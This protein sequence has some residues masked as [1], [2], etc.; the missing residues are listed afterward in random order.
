MAGVNPSLAQSLARQLL[1]IKAMGITMLVIEHNMSVIAEICDQ[2]T[3]LAAGK[4][5]ARGSF[6]EI[7]GNPPIWGA[8]HEPARGLR[9]GRRL[10]PARFDPQGR[11]HRGRRG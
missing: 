7:R 4:V 2:V 3:V 1:D 10:R 6:A 8:G 5:L 11:E 9:S